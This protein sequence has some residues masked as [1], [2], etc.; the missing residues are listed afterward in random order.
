MTFDE[1]VDKVQDQKPR[2]VYIDPWDCDLLEE[3]G[4]RSVDIDSAES[5][6]LVTREVLSW[7][8]TDTG[9]GLDVLYLDDE[10]VALMFQPAPHACPDF[11]WRDA[12]A[13]QQVFDYMVSL[14]RPQHLEDPRWLATES[15]ID[16]II[17]W[18]DDYEFKDGFR[19]HL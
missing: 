5:P 4:L 19:S 12:P 6:R 15:A 16:G 13:K 17:A 8:C 10:A 3:L 2:T 14:I 1:I 11:L 18:V 7:C 9:V